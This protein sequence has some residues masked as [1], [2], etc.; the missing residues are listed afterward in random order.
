MLLM[1][2]FVTT[3]VLIPMGGDPKTLL[4]S[5][6]GLYLHLLCPVLG[7]ASYLFA[8]SHAG[9]GVWFLP[10]AVT[11]VY[12]LTMIL[13]NALRVFDG[14]YPFFRVHNQSIAATALWILVLIGMIGA[15]SALVI[16]ISGVF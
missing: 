4:L 10:V 8:E 12:G 6:S 15:I 1:T 9:W 7:T 11:L 13:L 14:P 3:C 16:V 5:G 2:L